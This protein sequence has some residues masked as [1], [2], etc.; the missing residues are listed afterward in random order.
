[1]NEV[2]RN[3]DQFVPEKFTVNLT[4]ENM[5]KSLNDFNSQSFPNITTSKTWTDEDIKNLIE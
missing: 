5:L 1:L 4:P 2:A 3:L